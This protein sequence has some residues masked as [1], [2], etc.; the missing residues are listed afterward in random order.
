MS[1]VPLL[2]VRNLGL[3]VGERMLIGNLS[4][5]VEAGEVWCVLGPNGTGK[6]LLL[7]TL[8]GLRDIDR[9]TISLAGKPLARWT[10]LDAA[11]FR[12]FLP[13]TQDE[14]FGT[15]V[16]EAALLGRHPHLSRWQWESDSDREIA[17]NALQAVG[18]AG[19]AHRDVSTLSGG[20]RRR[21]AIAAL[22]VQDAAL[23]LLDEPAAHL[24]LHHQLQVLRHL[25]SL[26][27]EC[28]RAIVFS[29]HDLNL[30]RRFATHS[31]L[32]RGDG[33][34][35]HGPAGEVMSEAALSLAFGHP[36]L[37]ASVGQREIFMPE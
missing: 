1:A 16:L 20:E 19:L 12:G 10:T 27:K 9:G 21:V 28:G 11:R 36:V 3:H 7:H 32:F 5:D 8:A 14:A 23:M 22:L 18:V 35:D 29:V 2:E 6:T 13:Q 4:L 15:T 31:M 33:E 37:R 34:V 25:E 30:A 17:R 26:A 24:D